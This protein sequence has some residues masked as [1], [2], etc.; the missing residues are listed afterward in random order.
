MAKSKNKNLHRKENIKKNRY[1]KYKDKIYSTNIN[2]IYLKFFLAII[3]CNFFTIIYSSTIKMTVRTENE[4]QTQILGNG[5]TFSK[6]EV[7][8][9]NIN[10]NLGANKA[11]SLS[12]GIDYTI[13]LN[14]TGPISNCVNMFKDV[15]SLLEIN[16]S[17]FDSLGV[18]SMENMF[19]GCINLNK[20]VISN[21]N[22]KNVI[23]MNHMFTN[24]RNLCQILT[25]NQMDILIQCLSI[26][27]H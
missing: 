12:A 9:E 2:K 25:L 26:A 4:G 17:D 23:D 1:I 8:I 27:F 13:I 6:F 5:F 21:I 18:R 20:I 11:P 19:S 22:T 3:F 16:L 7:I 24:C 10:K 15:I 14:I